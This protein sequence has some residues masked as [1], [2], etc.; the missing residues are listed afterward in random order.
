V[1]YECVTGQDRLSFPDV[2]D[3]WGGEP[4]SMAAFEFMEIVLRAAEGNP[5]RRYDGTDEMLAD[6]VLRHGHKVG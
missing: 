3:K 1:L 4:E 5:D 6:L 2:P